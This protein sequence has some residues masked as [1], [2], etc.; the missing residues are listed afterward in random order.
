MGFESPRVSFLK[1]TYLQMK[2]YLNNDRAIFGSERA[3]KHIIDS[4]ML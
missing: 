1:E 4:N 2:M 3:N